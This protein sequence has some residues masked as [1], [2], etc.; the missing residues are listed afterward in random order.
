MYIDTIIHSGDEL[1]IMV[2]YT[3]MATLNVSCHV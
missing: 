3:A 1:F 2:L